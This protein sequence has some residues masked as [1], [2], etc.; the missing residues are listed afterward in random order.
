MK[1]DK[2]KEKENLDR[3]NEE[4]IRYY[5]DYPK[6]SISLTAIG[7]SISDGLSLSEPGLPLLKRNLGLI[8][9]GR[10]YGIDINIYQL[11]R[12]ESNNSFLV[13]D[14]IRKN[15]TELDSNRWNM[16]DY[17]RN[18]IPALR[19]DEI[20]SLFDGGSKKGIQDIIFDN[21][22]GNANI[23]IINLG[24]G[25]FL[26]VI[27]RHGRIDQIFASVDRDIAGIWS[28]LELIQSNN[29]VSG[30]NTQVYL[31]GAPRI[32]NTIISDITINPKM[33]RLASNY[34]NVTYVP[35]FPKQ[36]F[37]RT[38]AGII[39]DLHYNEAE[40]YHLL[41]LINQSIIDN[42]LKRD[43]LT[44][45]DRKIYTISQENDLNNGHYSLFD[46]TDLVDAM[47]KEYESKTGDYNFFIDFIKEYIA[48]RYPYDY[49]QSY[50][51]ENLARILDRMKK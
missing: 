28:I 18:D 23:V 4:L 3:V 35:A 47:A 15:H 7:N 19:Q 37:Y 9:I 44:I 21:H 33:K 17:V 34:A 39:T 1:Y 14:W 8:D 6:R 22:T 5:K 42:Y 31:C 51:K 45:L 49:Y 10:L 25:S 11:S 29:R 50:P 27:T 32:Y 41:S 20:N 24:T 36:P 2:I 46:I 13:L 43:L 16:I 30:S 40:Y 26:D 48:K 12:R 38:K